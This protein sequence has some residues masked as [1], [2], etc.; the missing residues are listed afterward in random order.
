MGLGTPPPDGGIVGGFIMA[1]D[2]TGEVILP[3]PP[4]AGYC[5]AEAALGLYREPELPREFY[6]PK[7]AFGLF[8]SADGT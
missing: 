3:L 5:A 8:V 4:I 1:G 2:C 7:S 6:L